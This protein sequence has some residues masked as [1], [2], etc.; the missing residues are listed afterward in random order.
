MMEII[1]LVNLVIHDMLLYN[2]KIYAQSISLI[3]KL[4]TCIRNFI[5]FGNINDRNMITVK[6]I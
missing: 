1:Q 5:W 4:D 2:L 6:W 3:N